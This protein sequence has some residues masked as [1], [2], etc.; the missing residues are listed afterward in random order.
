MNL[1]VQYLA[2]WD[3]TAAQVEH[4]LRGKGASPAQSKQTV[5]RLSDLRYLNDRAYALRWV[6]SRL[7]RKPMGRERLKAELLAKGVAE[8]LADRAIRE[9]MRGIDE[10]TLARRVLKAKQRKGGR[11]APV[12]AI[13]LLRQRGFEEEMIDRVIGPRGDE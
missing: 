9:V 11:L 1:A 10:E 2:R 6:E 5:G 8:S 4:F 13:R 7:A 12:S 3:R